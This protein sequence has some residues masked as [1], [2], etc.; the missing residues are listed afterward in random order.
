MIQRSDVG[1]GQNERTKER[2]EARWSRGK[3]RKVSSR[4]REVSAC[5]TDRQRDKESD[6]EGAREREREAEGR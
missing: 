1:G 5:V 4:A 6:S 2:R 3:D